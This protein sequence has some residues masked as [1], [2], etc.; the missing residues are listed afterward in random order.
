MTPCKPNLNKKR[1]TLRRTDQMSL[2]DDDVPQPEQN[3][4]PR[5]RKGR[6]KKSLS[7]DTHP[8]EPNYDPDTLDLFFDQNFFNNDPSSSHSKLQA[9]K[10]AD[11]KPSLTAAEQGQEL[12]VGT[13]KINAIDVQTLLR[14]LTDIRQLLNT[15]APDSEDR[16]L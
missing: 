13:R 7:K 11:Q 8:P 10:E 1:K 2:L 4:A 12:P 14:D 3:Q 5:T 16:D 6:P 15:K 9:I